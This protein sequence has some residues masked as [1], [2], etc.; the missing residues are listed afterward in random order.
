M[1]GWGRFFL[2]AK[3][4]KNKEKKKKTHMQ[5]SRFVIFGEESDHTVN[6]YIY[7]RKKMSKMMNMGKGF[8]FRATCG[9]SIYRIELVA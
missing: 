7:W 8:C 2:T 3:G 5:N 9:V 6:I 4:K 1:M